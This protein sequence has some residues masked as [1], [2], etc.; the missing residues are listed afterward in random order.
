MLQGLVGTSAGRAS[1]RLCYGALEASEA[2]TGHAVLV[3]DHCV[4]HKRPAKF[5]QKSEFQS[6]FCVDLR[7]VE[8]GDGS[9]P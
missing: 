2:S 7:P 5:A 8:D 1:C 9:R 3:G 4:V 6:T